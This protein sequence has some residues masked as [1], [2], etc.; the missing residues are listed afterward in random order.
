MGKSKARRKR[1][2]K[3]KEK[4]KK[5]KAVAS[6]DPPSPTDSKTQSDVPGDD[7]DPEI[8]PLD[9]E[10]ESANDDYVAQD[11]SPNVQEDTSSSIDHLP[12]QHLQSGSQ[13]VHPAVQGSG[14]QVARGMEDHSHTVAQVVQPPTSPQLPPLPDTTLSIRSG[15]Y[16]EP[17]P[18]MSHPVRAQLFSRG[19]PDQQPAPGQYT[20]GVSIVR[21]GD[22]SPVWDHSLRSLV[23][24]EPDLDLRD[25]VRAAQQR[26]E[27]LGG[28]LPVQRSSVDDWLAQAASPVE[29][30]PSLA[31]PPQLGDGPPPERSSLER[32]VFP[33]ESAA[34]PDPP[35]PPL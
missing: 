25:N 20:P 32:P 34:F 12:S 15:T 29:T 8:D 21:A 14:S 13:D 35:Q 18:D 1:D 33:T 23:I 6:S 2:K 26:R 31:Q 27:I 30:S 10:D 5:A 16:I 17:D 24:R 19:R 3:K 22:P 28:D 7:M 9:D 11:S 4:K